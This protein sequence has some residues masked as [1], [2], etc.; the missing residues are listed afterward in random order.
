MKRFR[1]VPGAVLL[2]CVAAWGQDRAFALAEAATEAAPEDGTRSLLLARRAFEIADVEPARSALYAALCRARERAILRGHTGAVL[3]V[4]VSADGGTVATGGE[5]GTVRLWTPDGKEIATLAVG[6]PVTDVRFLG[7][8]V[9]VATAEELSIRDRAGKKLASFPPAPFDIQGAVLSLAPTPETL[10][11]VDATGK[12]LRDLK[13]RA[14]GRAAGEFTFYAITSDGR[15]RWYDAKNRERTIAPAA[16]TRCAVFAPSAPILATYGTGIAVQLWSPQCRKIGELLH[17]GPVEQV[18]MSPD[19]Q[20][21]FTASADGNYAFWGAD[22][23]RQAR[24][25]KAGPCAFAAVADDGLHV[26]TLDDGDQVTLWTWDGVPVSKRFPGIVSVTPNDRC[27]GLILD[28]KDGTRRF[29]HSGLDEVRSADFVGGALSF[30]A[31]AGPWLLV[32]GEDGHAA[33]QH[34]YGPGPA[35]LDGHAGAILHAAFSGDR[36]LVVTGSRD[37]TAR[38]WHVDSPT[39]PAIYHPSRVT[40]IGYEPGRLL[41]CSARALHIRETDGRLV[42]EIELFSPLLWWGHGEGRVAISCKDELE[43]VLFDLD[44]KEI[45]RLKHDGLIR[46]VEVSPKGDLVVSFSADRTAKLWDGRGRL[47]ATLEHPQGVGSAAFSA[48][49]SLVLTTADDRQARVWSAEGELLATF[50]VPEE[51]WYCVFS[52]KGDRLVGIPTKDPVPRVWSSKGEVIAD[53]AGH[54]GAVRAAVFSPEG[55]A[56]VTASVDGTARLWTADGK[57]GPVLPHPDQVYKGVFLPG[58][59]GVVTSCR[60]GAVRHWDRGGRLL[61]VMRGHVQPVWFV[62]CTLDGNTLATASE[63][64][65]V[66]LWPLGRDDLLRLSKER[67]VRDF[68]PEERDRYG[69]LLEPPQ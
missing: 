24:V 18:A 16:G 28:F 8:S 4:H 42:K 50:P 6:K 19:G 31:W 17:A 44:G 47:R 32:A 69:P 41:T 11:L 53:L 65:T 60:D 45:A 46:G 7:D 38:V 36:T 55:D 51:I 12:V 23:K 29:V 30:S 33:L 64:T 2:L 39:V 5:D 27:L 22:G 48:D 14:G 34:W 35:Y 1:G 54:E 21:I 10:R 52:P 3:R 62:E 26:V 43:A 37:G 59:K 15:L 58:G 61:A 40:G 49:G 13:A 63:D 25:A 57:P 67:L 66:R 56:I 68:T 20:R 9:V